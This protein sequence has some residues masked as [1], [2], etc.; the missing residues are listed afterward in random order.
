[1]DIP[2]KTKSKTSCIILTDPET[3]CSGDNDIPSAAEK[4]RKSSKNGSSIRELL[5]NQKTDSEDGSCVNAELTKTML[6]VCVY[7]VLFTSYVLC[8]ESWTTTNFLCVCVGESRRRPTFCIGE[9]PVR[10]VFVERSSMFLF[11]HKT[12]RFLNQKQKN[13]VVIRGAVCFV[14]NFFRCQTSYRIYSP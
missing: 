8:F 13:C 12:F 6:C 5:H 7:C 11:R 1:M 10:V 9:P 4:E 14:Q 2:F 3:N